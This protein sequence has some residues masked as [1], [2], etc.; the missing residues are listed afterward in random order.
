MGSGDL[1]TGWKA[2]KNERVA[3]STF[4]RHTRATDDAAGG[5]GSFAPLDRH[6]CSMLHP[7]TTDRTGSGRLMSRL[8]ADGNLR[9]GELRRCQQVAMAR[10]WRPTSPRRACGGCDSID[11]PTTATFDRMECRACAPSRHA[12]AA[13]RYF[14]SRVRVAATASASRRRQSDRSVEGCQ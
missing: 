5:G 13:S 14:T 6:R 4:G 12:S 1:R 2:P 9:P 3:R 10:P 7:P 8:N 11:K